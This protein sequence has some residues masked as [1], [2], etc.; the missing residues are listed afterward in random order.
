MPLRDPDPE[1]SGR[2]QFFALRGEPAVGAADVA[3]A[4]AEAGVTG[5]P[6][7]LLELTPEGQQ[8]FESLTRTASEHI[9]IVV[10]GVLLS[11][12]VLNTPAGVSAAEG[13]QISGGLT[14]EDAE[15]M[16]DGLAAGVP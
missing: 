8:S 16:A 12:P 10:D 1:G 3:S 4:S 2:A 13:I 7:V 11:L 15:A 9:A 5:E 6:T 14:Q